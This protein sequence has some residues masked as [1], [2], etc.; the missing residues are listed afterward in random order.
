M[1]RQEKIISILQAV[2]WGFSPLGFATEKR[3]ERKKY[4]ERKFGVS[5]VLV[6]IVCGNPASVLSSLN[7][8]CIKMYTLT[9][10]CTPTHTRK[11][12]GSEANAQWDP[13]FQPASQY[14]HS[15]VFSVE[16]QALSHMLASRKS[17]I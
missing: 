6:M 3:K 13:S 1:D 7:T 8:H 10:T 14:E 5:G 4:Q 17:D 16:W 9:H 12:T 2:C 15:P 11:V